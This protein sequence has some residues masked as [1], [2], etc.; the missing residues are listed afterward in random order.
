MNSNSVEALQAWE[1]INHLAHEIG[2]RP[3]GSPAVKKTLVYLQ[4]QL[5]SWGYQCEMQ[6]FLFADNPK[7]SPYYSI[8]ALFFVISAWAL[9]NLPLIVLPLPFVVAAL[10]E[11]WQII[12]RRRQTGKK[13]Q[14]LLAIPKNMPLEKLDLILSAHVDTARQN[15][16]SSKI[17]RNLQ[18]N[19]FVFMQRIAW[20]VLFFALFFWVGFQVPVEVKTALSFLMVGFALFLVGMDVWE[21]LAHQNQF[22]PG[23][24][25]NASGVSI[26]MVLADF[27]RLNLEKNPKVGFLFTDAEETGMYGA[28]AF[29]MRMK[30]AGLKTPVIVLDQVGAGEEIRVVRGVGRFKLYKSDETLADLIYRVA[31]DAHDLFYIYRNGDFSSF[32]RAGIP[33]I[34]IETSG[35]ENA[36]QAYHRMEDT[37]RVVQKETLDRVIRLMI[38]LLTVYK[39]QNLEK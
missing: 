30:Q 26:L 18:S 13:A 36:K 31:P 28:E 32:L 22:V 27:L 12:Q 1:I 29:A 24:V 9:I 15:P 35:S 7:F 2:P 20:M 38:K 3:A 4:D 14:N 34:S 8:V 11:L 6:D 5:L 25:D 39:N 37:I 33:A 19:L 10:P 21:Q 17:G 16:V 23:A